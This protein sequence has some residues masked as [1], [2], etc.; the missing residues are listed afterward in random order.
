MHKH[1]HSEYIP[2]YTCKE[3]E[4]SEDAAGAVLLEGTNLCVSLELAAK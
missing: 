2:Q 4:Y 1:L 3:P